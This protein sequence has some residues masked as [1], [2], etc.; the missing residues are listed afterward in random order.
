M[1]FLYI[2]LCDDKFFYVG[3]TN[4]LERRLDEHK[5]K[6][7]FL[8]NVFQKLNWSIKKVTLLIFW[9]EKEK[10]KLKDGVERKK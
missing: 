1:C 9:Q 7:S 3:I 8:Q 2:L 10:K 4:N 5:N 6:K